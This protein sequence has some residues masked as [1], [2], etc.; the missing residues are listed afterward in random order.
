MG[1]QVEEEFVGE[2]RGL[3]D[4]DYV[5]AAIAVG[6]HMETKCESDVGF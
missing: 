5:L 1:A 4:N 2:V 3:K 6:K